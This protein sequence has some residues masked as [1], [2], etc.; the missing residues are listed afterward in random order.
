M[1][2]GKTSEI[3]RAFYKNKS[4]EITGASCWLYRGNNRFQFMLSRNV[5]KDL[6][7][8]AAQPWRAQFSA[9][10]INHNYVTAQGQSLL[11]SLKLLSRNSTISLRKLKVHHRVHNSL[12]LISLMSQTKPAQPSNPTHL[13]LVSLL[14]FSLRLYHRREIFPYFPTIHF[15]RL[16][17]LMCATC[18]AQ[19]IPLDLTFLIVFGG[20]NSWSASLC[21][22]VQPPASSSVLTLN[23]LA[24][25]TVG[26]RINP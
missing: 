14:P 8:H 10:G 16:F 18:P 26:A 12:S 4:F 1:M 9:E 25:T 3:C 24:P 5:G 11:T 23:L 13:M 22:F 20:H 17:F 7:L 21:N 6:P 15:M 19:I 2:D